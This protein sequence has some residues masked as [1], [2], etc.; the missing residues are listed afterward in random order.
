[1]EEGQDIICLITETPRGGAHIIFESDDYLSRC[2]QGKNISRLF[3]H[4]KLFKFKDLLLFGSKYNLILL[5]LELPLM[6][7][8][9]SLKPLIRQREDIWMRN[10]NFLEEGLI[11]EVQRNNSL[12]EM[13]QIINTHKRV[14]GEPAIVLRDVARFLCDPP[15]S[16]VRWVTVI[17]TN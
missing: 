4:F 2:K 8:P 6:V 14:F 1:M 13:T 11:K 3:L 5:P 15:Y 12:F 9:E 7:V 17:V 10:I 16:N